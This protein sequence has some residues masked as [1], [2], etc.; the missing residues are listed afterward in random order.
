MP[1]FIAAAVTV[2]VEGGAKY[3]DHGLVTSLLYDV[4]KTPRG[5]PLR[6]EV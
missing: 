4:V 6:L 3:V 1:F 2:K 5:L